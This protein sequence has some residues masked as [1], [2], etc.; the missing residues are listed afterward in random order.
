VLRKW[1][2]RRHAPQTIDG[3]QCIIFTKQLIRET[4]E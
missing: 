1:P 2:K 3:P 4:E